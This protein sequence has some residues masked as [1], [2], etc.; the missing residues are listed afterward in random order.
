MYYG[1]KLNNN[2]SS[3]AYN[4]TGQPKDVSATINVTVDMR[5]ISVTEYTKTKDLCCVAEDSLISMADGTQ[6]QIKDIK[7]G[8]KVLSYNTTTRKIEQTV[9]Q[10]L[11][12]VIRRDIVH[13]TFADGSYIKITPDHPMFSERGWIAY[14]TADGENT[15]PE[16]ELE[17]QGTQIGDMILSLS[18]LFDKEIVDMKYITGETIP[19]YTFTVDN[20]H[21]Y[22]AQSVLI[23][24]G[25]IIPCQLLCCVDGETDITMADGTTKKAKDVVVGDEVLSYNDETKQYEKTTI[26]ETINPYREKI[27]EITFEDGSTLK[28]TD[29]H[30]LLSARG[31]ICY[32]PEL[33]QMAYGTHGVSDKAMQVGDK[34]IT[35]TGAKTIASIKVI[36]FEDFEM[37]YTFRLANGLA[38]IAN[39]N[40]VA[41]VIK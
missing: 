23:H 1:F 41:S 11:T 40:I 3:S 30:P 29:D 18:L 20:N 21:N 27:L 24:N 22:F 15:Y 4:E 39:G 14:S 19:V 38:F 36:E 8:D 35:E 9:V 28:I 5:S 34:I 10:S 25:P 37:V 31:W 17:K 26:E 12:K 16:V 2:Y 33:G 13:I 6:K 7:V 32:N